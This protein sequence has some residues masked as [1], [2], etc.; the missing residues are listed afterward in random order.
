MELWG[1]NLP[2]PRAGLHPKPPPP[3][4]CSG[5]AGAPPRLL[6][7]LLRTRL[8]ARR[9]LLATHA[10]AAQQGEEQDQ[11]Q[12]QE[13]TSPDHPHPLVGLWKR[14]KAGPRQGAEGGCH[15]TPRRTATK[16]RPETAA[17]SAL[18]PLPPPRPPSPPSSQS[19][20]RAPLSAPTRLPF[21]PRRMGTGPSAPQPFP[22]GRTHVAASGQG[23]AGVLVAAAE[24]LTVHAELARRARQVAA[25]GGERERGVSR[26]KGLD[27]AAPSAEPG[28][29]QHP[30][31][32]EGLRRP[33]GCHWKAALVRQH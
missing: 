29:F 25:G 30:Q 28:P 19:S 18:Y 24:L 12:G 14:R 13:G 31:L 26:G 32:G 20:R 17:P 16:Q 2:P 15:S 8:L 9:I 3:G 7:P 33:P 11:Q 1:V 6:Q 27:G 5:L 23:V 4:A 10:A 22:G 21:R